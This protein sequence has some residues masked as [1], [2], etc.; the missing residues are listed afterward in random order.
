MPKASRAAELNRDRDHERSGRQCERLAAAC[1]KPRWSMNRARPQY[2]C[3]F[4]F[5]T[6]PADLTGR[7]PRRLPTSDP[8]TAEAC[9]ASSTGSTS[10]IEKISACTMSAAC[11]HQSRRDEASGTIYAACATRRRA[12]DPMRAY[13]RKFV[14]APSPIDSDRPQLSCLWPCAS[15]QETRLEDRKRCHG[16]LR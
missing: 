13:R 2:Q 3:D 7:A 16:R 10:Q 14:S 11:R 15:T 4:F 6:K 9:G 1:I 12:N 8:S 5:P